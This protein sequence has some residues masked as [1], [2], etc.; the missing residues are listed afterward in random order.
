MRGNAAQIDIST[1]SLSHCR[2]DV[3]HVHGT[4]SILATL[5]AGTYAP[6]L[7]LGHMAVAMLHG[8]NLTLLYLRPGAAHPQLQLQ[9][10]F[11]TGVLPSQR[12][13]PPSPSAGH[14]VTCCVT[15]EAPRRVR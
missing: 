9:P 3:V 2:I 4:V 12:R 10:Y 1:G 5:I 8:P 15:I 14:L 11:A 6:G 7:R 13:I